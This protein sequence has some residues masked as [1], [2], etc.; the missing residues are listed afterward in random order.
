M[1]FLCRKNENFIEK[2]YNAIKDQTVSSESHTTE[3]QLQ[4]H[5][6][7]IQMTKDRYGNAHSPDTLLQSREWVLNLYNS[8][9]PNGHL[10]SGDPIA[11]TSLLQQSTILL[12]ILQSRFMNHI[13][14]RL[15]DTPSKK[16]HWC[17]PWIQKNLSSVA[18]IM[19]MFRHMKD[20]I[21]CL[22][23]SKTLLN[24]P[25]NFIL[26]TNDEEKKH[27]VYLYWDNNDSI[28]IRSGKATGVSNDRGFLV[29]HKEH[30]KKAKS[31]QLLQNTSRFYVMYPS[32]YSSRSSSKS[33]KGLFETLCQHVAFGYNHNWLQS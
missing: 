28:W 19:V 2:E 11:D 3:N 14:R 24:S 5:E 20:D 17:I 25:N 33:K 23:E 29:R 9:D 32:K 30:L 7:Y 26:V 12:N 13:E 1:H 31:T 21:S 27:G 16:S 18:A 10:I 22:D 4:S 15:S 8:L 6:V